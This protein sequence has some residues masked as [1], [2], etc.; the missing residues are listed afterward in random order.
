MIDRRAI[1]L[2]NVAIAA[3]I[4]LILEPE[5]LLTAS[6]QMSFAATLG[7]VAGYEALRDRADRTL[8]LANLADRGLA[9]RL[10]FSAH[11]LFLTSLIAALATTPF[12]IYHFQRAAPLALLANLAAMPV[13]GLLVMPAALFA[14]ILMPLG[15]ESLA[16]VPMSWGIDWFVRV[17][18]VVAEWSE[19]WG[20]IRAAPSAA[21]LLVVA[22]FLWLALWR[23]RWRVAGIVP[24]LAAIPIA[25]AAPV[26]D[27]LIDPGG[28]TAAVRGADGR[29]SIINPKADR[30][31]AEYWLRADADPRTV[32][33]DL[34]SGV[35]CDDVGCVARLA[36]GGLV[37]VGSTPEAF[38]DDCRL[39]EVVVSR[40]RAP[41]WCFETATVID[42][43]AL[44]AGGSQALYRLPK[45]EPDGGS[46]RIETSYPEG[47]R[48]PFMP[49]L[50]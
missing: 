43:A 50:Q 42:R 18:E 35:T 19:G 9:G 24:M 41:S 30:F 21:L 7:L 39:A 12:A 8:S 11:G 28:R 14:V 27:V 1:T 33:D 6:F 5:S 40:H 13:V 37:A 45:A 32:D 34:S 49:P 3:L 2:R 16:L 38:V 26:P 31:A 15:L 4:V 44:A 36:D 46:F 20:G 25:L 47:V 17:G 10:W 48:R 22:G 29:Y 23:E